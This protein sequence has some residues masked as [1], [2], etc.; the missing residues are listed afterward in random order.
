MTVVFDTRA[1]PADERAEAIRDAMQTASVPSH[2][3]HEDPGGPVHGIFEMWEFG[4]ASIFR[5]QMSGIR[6]RRTPRQVRAFE[7]PMLA[8]AV[9][10]TGLGHYEQLDDQRTVPVG[11]LHVMDLNAPYDFRW[12]G[13]GASTCLY[14]PLDRLELPAPQIRAAARQVRDSALYRLVADHIVAMTS[15]ADA[16]CLGPAATA[17]GSASVELVRGLLISASRPDC[18]AAIAPGEVLLSRI[19]AYVDRHLGDPDLDAAR[20]AHAHNISV[21]YLYKVCAAAD[22]SLAQW[23]IGERLARIRAE[24]A[25]PEAQHRS[26]AAIAAQWGFRNQ[27]HFTRRFRHAYGIAPRE[28]RR[29]ASESRPILDTPAATE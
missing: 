6:L 9:Q 7:A 19:R 23:I 15:G 3:V 12:S 26:I 20:I 4:P 5:A 24:L 17:T 11:E 29:I 13:S 21:R 27:S 1:F 25:R 22:Y 28:W 18:D 10:Q 8:I 16:L 2:V 14:V